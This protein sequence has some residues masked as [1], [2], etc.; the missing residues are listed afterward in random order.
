MAA[1]E[2]EPGAAVILTDVAKAFER[3]LLMV[4]WCQTMKFV[5]SQKDLKGAVWF[6]R[7]S[8]NRVVRCF[9]RGFAAHD[10]CLPPR[11]NACLQLEIVLR[12]A[13]TEPTNPHVDV[14]IH[15]EVSV[16]SM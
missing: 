8:E 6:L 16:R 12:D 1:G 15:T 3:I 13:V 14:Q 9:F 4:A 5:F 11:E 10:Y 2:G 7:T